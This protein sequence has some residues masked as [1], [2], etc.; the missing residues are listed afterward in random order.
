MA[1]HAVKATMPAGRTTANQEF[2]LL[3]AIIA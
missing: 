1:S 3:I 2:G